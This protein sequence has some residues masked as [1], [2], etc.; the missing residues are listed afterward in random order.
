MARSS[1][2]LG[3]LHVRMGKVHLECLQWAGRFVGAVKL[4]VDV[5]CKPCSYAGRV[6]PVW[7]FRNMEI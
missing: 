1:E 5:A 2:N 7:E 3:F 4:N 6:A